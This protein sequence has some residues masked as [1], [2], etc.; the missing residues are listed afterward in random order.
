[1]VRSDSHESF[2][3]LMTGGSRIGGE[4]LQRHPRGALAAVLVPILMAA[5]GGCGAVENS[6]PHHCRRCV[7]QRGL[8]VEIRPK[9]Q[10]YV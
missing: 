6:A 5:A 3:P 10:E 2:R 7:R 1:V 9:P 8:C 4:A